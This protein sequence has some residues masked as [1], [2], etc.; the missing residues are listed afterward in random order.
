MPG[1]YGVGNGT[2]WW[3]RGPKY[4]NRRF[5][6]WRKP[7]NWGSMEYGN[8]RPGF[9]NRVEVPRVKMGASAYWLGKRTPQR[10][11]MARTAMK[12]GRR[13][14]AVGLYARGALRVPAR[15]KIVGA[16]VAGVAAF[17]HMSRKREKFYTQYFDY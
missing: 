5:P 3:G 10:W 9:R 11:A 6:D 8:G 13:G 2:P 16:A 7:Q 12:A 17:A 15:T 14:E 1:F 4:I